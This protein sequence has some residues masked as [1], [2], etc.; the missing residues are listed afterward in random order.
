ILSPHIIAHEHF[1]LDCTFCHPVWDC[2][3]WG[4]ENAPKSN[5][6]RLPPWGESDELVYHRPF[7]DGYSG[8]CYH[9]FE[10]TWFRVRKR[11]SLCTVL[12][13]FTAGADYHFGFHYPDLLQAK[14]VHSL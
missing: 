13:W 14:S 8:Q 5:G 10:C 6:G 7:G 11:P 3:F 9:L 1:R 2:R 12:L 4:V